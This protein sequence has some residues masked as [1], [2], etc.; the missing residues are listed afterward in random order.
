MRPAVPEASDILA[1]FDDA[2]RKPLHLQDLMMAL[3]LPQYARRMLEETLEAM[4]ARG[5]L[6]RMSGLRYRRAKQAP[7][8]T[9]GYYTHNPRGF[10]FLHPDDGSPDV[11]VSSTGVGA[12]M[13]GDRVAVRAFAGDRGPEGVVTRVVERRSQRIPGTLRIRGDSAYL[14]C[15]DLRV[16]GP[17]VIESVENAPDGA[18]VVCEI[19]RFPEMGGELPVARV[20]KVLGRPGQL[21][22]EVLKVILREGVEENFSPEAQAEAQAFGDALK[23]QDYEGR[24]DLRDI[25]LMTIDPEDARDHDDAVYVKR[26]EDGGYIALIAIADVSH[27]VQPGS[28]LDEEARAR[29][30]SIYLPDRAITMLPRELSTH[31]ASLKEGQDRLTLAVEV[32]LTGDARI[33]KVRLIEGVMRSHASLT[34]ANL[35]SELGW[36]DTAKPHPKAREHH[37]ALAVAAELSALLKAR[38]VRRGALMLD[39]PEG[40]VKFAE[41]TKIPV[42]IVQSRVDE[43]MKRAYSVIE[44][45]MLLANEVI[46]EY[47]EKR[48]VTTVY[49]THAAPDKDGLAKLCAVAHALGYDLEPEEAENPKQLGKFLRKIAKDPAVKIM[50]FLLL[51]TLPQAHYTIENSGHFGLA[52]EAYLHFTSP[53][54]RYPDLLVHRVVRQ[55]VRKERLRRDDEYVAAMQA[56]AVL[57]SRLE[58]RAMDIEREVLE[59]HRCVVAQSHIDSTFDAVISSVTV[60]GAYAQ[61]AAPFLDV[62]VRAT[63]FG[64]DT[65][66]LDALGLS[67]RGKRTGVVFKSGQPVRITIKDVSMARRSILATLSADTVDTLRVTHKRPLKRRVTR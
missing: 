62:L 35:A 5:M 22:V 55:L 42:D 41:D 52:S 40:R 25:P 28:R 10:G 21:D 56:S 23:P 43:G 63:E 4:A 2:E 60:H 58:R 46:A 53:I 16:R 27:Y 67:I 50:H 51:R 26:S 17:L 65:W 20:H 12:A 24:E 59:L 36:S 44:E 1:L 39:V 32:K 34:Y 38:R 57:A 48:E 18:A 29:G 31:L 54:R 9:I 61:T 66:E 8:E 14:E 6:S 3:G 7:I 11:F 33:T 15:D 30:T 47:C 19:T 64:E 37:E 49:R 45:L 13:H